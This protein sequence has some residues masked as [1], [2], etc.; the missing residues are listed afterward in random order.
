MS[1]TLSS[2][3]PAPLLSS[4]ER[5]ALIGGAVVLVLQVFPQTALLEYRRALLA[6]EPWRALSGHFVHINWTHVAINVAAW[7]VVAR[8]FA[9]DLSA[10]RQAGALVLSALGISV[11]LATIFPTIEWYRGLSGALHGL[12][13]AG[14]TVWLVKAR[15]RT[16]ATLWLPAALWIGGWIK[17]ALEQPIGAATPYVDWLQAGVVPQAHLAG[18]AFGTLFGLAVAALDAR[19]TQQRQQQ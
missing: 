1:R 17:V 4:A 7:W 15:P 19:R 6:T 8:L 16:A 2:P 3:K 10:R 9:P 11:V 12:F 18:A 13:F 5:F 14:A